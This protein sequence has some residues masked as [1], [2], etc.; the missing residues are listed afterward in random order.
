MRTPQSIQDI[1]TVSFLILNKAMAIP[2]RMQRVTR[3][4]RDA[5]MGVATLSG[6]MLRGR[7]RMTMIII[8]ELRR[9]LAMQAA[10]MLEPPMRKMWFG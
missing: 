2:D 4:P 9:K 6:L 3:S 10:D 7:D 8:T 5:A 1:R